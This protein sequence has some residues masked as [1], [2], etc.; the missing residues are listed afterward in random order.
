LAE[1]EKEIDAHQATALEREGHVIKRLNFFD[2][3]ILSAEDFKDEQTY[4]IE[5]RQSHNRHVHGAG[6]VRGL[7]VSVIRDYLAVQPGYAIDC[8]GRDIVVPQAIKLD[9]PTGKAPIFVTL[10]YV[11]TKLCQYPVLSE[12]IDSYGEETSERLEYSR[13]KEE[14]KF[15][16][17]VDDPFHGHVQFRDLWTACGK[18]HAVPIGRIKLLGS[19]WAI[20]RLYSLLL[21]RRGVLSAVAGWILSL[22]FKSR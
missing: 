17:Q 7:G 21:H 8:Q 10:R 22:K 15:S 2:G 13:I 6:I 9:L 4:H 14:F 16:Y 1:S 3:Q 12:A 5:K 19:H 18:D 20:D 11:E